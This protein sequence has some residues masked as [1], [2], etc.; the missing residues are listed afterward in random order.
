MLKQI[1]RMTMNIVETKRPK[2]QTK[3]PP[4]CIPAC[5]LGFLLRGVALDSALG[6]CLLQFSN[7]CLGEIGV[8]MEIQLP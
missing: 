2:G 6:Q 4:G 7:L 3:E 8:V 1:L 5:L